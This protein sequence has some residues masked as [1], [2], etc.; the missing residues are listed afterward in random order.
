LF[1]LFNWF[2]HD[3]LLRCFILLFFFEVR[4]L[5]FLE[6][7]EEI[8]PHYVCLVNVRALSLAHL[9]EVVDQQLPVVLAHPP[10]LVQALVRNEGQLFM[11]RGVF[12][13]L[14]LQHVGEGSFL[15]FKELIIT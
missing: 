14:L 3:G 13:R 11:Q 2:I 5:L 9:D 15:I 8:C 6:V 10:G 7:R 1:G 12:L 4:L